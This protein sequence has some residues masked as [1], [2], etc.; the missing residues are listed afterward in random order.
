MFPAVEF[1]GMESS[2]P[3]AST[4]PALADGDTVRVMSAITHSCGAMN[5]ALKI[6]SAVVF[7]ACFSLI[8]LECGSWVSCSPH[9]SL[10]SFGNDFCWLQIVGEVCTPPRSDVQPITRCGVSNKQSVLIFNYAQLEMLLE[11]CTAN[12]SSSML[13]NSIFVAPPG[14]RDAAPSITNDWLE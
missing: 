14:A 8:D 1:L 11:C 2:C 7:I 9:P 3:N 5:I 13:S 6:L 4:S 10:H 12:P